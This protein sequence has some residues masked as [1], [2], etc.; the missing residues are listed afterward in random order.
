MNLRTISDQAFTENADKRA[1]IKAHVAH[2]R[3]TFFLPKNLQSARKPQKCELI[4]MPKNGIEEASPSC[5]IVIFKSQSAYGRTK[6]RLI[7]S[8]VA[9]IITSPDK[10]TIII[11]NRPCSIDGISNKRIIVELMTATCS[12]I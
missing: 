6:D 9:P 12:A 2:S 7:F 11:L 4:T 1:K 10:N 5:V 8:I 3:T